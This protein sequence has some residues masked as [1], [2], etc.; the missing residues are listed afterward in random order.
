MGKGPSGSQQRE[1]VPAKA[2]APTLATIEQGREQVEVQRVAPSAAC[3]C[4][5]VNHHFRGCVQ[6]GRPIV[7]RTP[8]YQGT[9]VT[10]PLQLLLR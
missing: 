6:L 1:V 4:G 8:M 7:Q 5:L 9:M 10:H 3:S 2:D